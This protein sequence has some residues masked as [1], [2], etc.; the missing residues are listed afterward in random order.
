MCGLFGLVVNDPGSVRNMQLAP[1]VKELFVRSETRGKESSGI[2]IANQSTIQVLKRDVRGRQFARSPALRR[3][4][5]TAD[6]SPFSLIGHTRMV[7]NGAAD[8]IRNNQPVVRDELVCIHNGIIVN[9]EALWQQNQ[10]LARRY[11]VDTEILLALIQ[12]Q[13]FEG[14]N[15]ISATTYAMSK[16]QGANTFAVFSG[17]QDGLIVAS[18]NGSLHYLIDKSGRWAFFASERFILEKVIGS[19][20][21]RL[22][23]NNAQITQLLAHHALI[24]GSQKVGTRI[25]SMTDGHSAIKLPEHVRE[26]RDCGSSSNAPIKCM[27]ASNLSRI[28]RLRKESRPDFTAI[29]KIR[30]CVTCLLPETFPFLRFNSRGVCS[31]CQAHQS[32][33][34]PGLSVLKQRLLQGDTTRSPRVLAPV[35]GGRDSCYGLHY[36]VE[37][38]GLKPIAYTYDWGLVTDLARRNISRICGALNVE[39]ILVSADIA[40]KREFVRKNV[41]A[42]LRRPHLGT[43]PLF[44]AGDK[45]FFYYAEKLRDQMHLDAVLYSM[46]PLERTD[47][48]VGFTGIDEGYTK[49][50]HYDPKWPNKLRLALFYGR[51]FL[52]NPTY[53]NRSLFDTLSAF[54]SYYALPKQYEQ[55]FDYIP[56]IE[57]DVEKTLIDQYDWELAPDTK[58]TW[59][60]GDGTAAFYN[61]IYLKVAGFTENDTFRSNQIREGLV[62]RDWALSKIEEENQVR[63]ESLAWYFDMIGLDAL[64]AIKRVNAIP[65]LY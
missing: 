63:I 62:S 48:K 31:I 28:S 5:A 59:R 12:Q 14:A 38:L 23:S 16:I 35:S 54:I 43:V 34:K 1:L 22:S 10:S 55:L 2:A 45:Q 60:I 50:R 51:E 20:Y 19:K 52:R 36:M 9:D 65:T 56:W 44:M 57:A 42:W 7:T 21:W 37:N 53:I 25:I 6:R 61:Y 64:D 33:P 24:I 3:M 39:H 27:P 41:S 46:N 58:S 17:K 49:S 15:L 47:F 18:A 8:D 29:E 11:S 30:R 4:L 13:I 26:V 40:K 32:K